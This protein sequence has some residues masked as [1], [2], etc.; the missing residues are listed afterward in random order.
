MANRRHMHA[1]WGW[2]GGWGLFWGIALI[3][4]GGYAL[5][6][7]LGLLWWLRGDIFWP[8]LLILLGVFLLVRRG[9]WW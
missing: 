2:W 7:N 6:S 4:F 3:L 5:L 8:S 1:T 9:R